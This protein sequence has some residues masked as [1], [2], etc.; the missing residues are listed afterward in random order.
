MRRWQAKRL[1][2]VDYR[3]RGAALEDHVGEAARGDDPEIP[4]VVASP[5]HAW[6]HRG[7]LFRRLLAQAAVIRR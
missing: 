6:H 1:G 2:D 5:G 3:L 4:L 7:A